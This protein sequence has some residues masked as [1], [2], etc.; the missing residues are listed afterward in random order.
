MLVYQRVI[1]ISPFYHI[2]YIHDFER[3]YEIWF[4]NGTLSMGLVGV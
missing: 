1:H 2:L 3:P 4:I